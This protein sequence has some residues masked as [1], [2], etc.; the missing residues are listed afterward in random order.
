M[1][2]IYTIYFDAADH[3]G[4]YAVRRFVVD[5]NGATPDATLR[6]ADSL[7]KARCYLPPGLHNLGRELGDEPQIVESWV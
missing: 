2:E 5:A 6:L 7:D 4:K 3:P 1:L